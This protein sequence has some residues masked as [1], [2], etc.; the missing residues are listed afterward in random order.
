[1]TN[2]A[3]TRGTSGAP[4]VSHEGGAIR[5]VGIISAEVNRTDQILPSY[6]AYHANIAVDVFGILRENPIIAKTIVEDILK[7]TEANIPAS[8]TATLKTCEGNNLGYPEVDRCINVLDRLS[9]SAMDTSTRDPVLGDDE[10]R[11]MW[12]SAQH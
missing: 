5:V 4:I 7:H 6:E 3:N 2:C 8:E 12:I 11:Q 1:M 9:S 10:L